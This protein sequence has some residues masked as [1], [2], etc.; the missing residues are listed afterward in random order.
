[1]KTRKS[2]IQTISKMWL[3]PEKEELD[4]NRFSIGKDGVI[5]IY[6]NNE[7][8]CFCVEFES[9]TKITLTGIEYVNWGKDC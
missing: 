6:M 3:H 4:F 2:K 5:D 8:G 1:M 7:E 9:G